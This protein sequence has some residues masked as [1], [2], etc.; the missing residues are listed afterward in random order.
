MTRSG[1]GAGA[2]SGGAGRISNMPARLL[3]QCR[4]WS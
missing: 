3:Q 2:G 1:A 4:L